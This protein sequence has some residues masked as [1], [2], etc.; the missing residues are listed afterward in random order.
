MLRAAR[1]AAVPSG[2]STWR[3]LLALPAAI[4]LSLGIAACGDDDGEAGKLKTTQQNAGVEITIGSKDDTEQV[5]LGQ[6]YAQA[7]EAAGYRVR[8][9]AD[10]RTSEAA[11]GAVESGQISGYPEYLS[12][13]LESFL[14]VAPA[15][16]PHDPVQAAARAK[17]GLRAR[18][19][20]AFKP[21]PYNRTYDVG[22]LVSR[23][24]ELTVE[25]LTD[26]RGK[27]Q[28]LTLAAPA[29]CLERADC[30]GALEQGYGL[31]FSDT[32]S[33]QVEQ[34]YA[35]LDSGQADLSILSTPDAKLFVSPSVYTSL[36]DDEGLFPAGNPIF[37][38]SRR[39]V[40]EAG[41]D[42]EATIER[43]Q[44]ALDLNAIQELNALVNI[45]GE[46]PATVARDYLLEE[47]YLK[48]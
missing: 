26:L 21:A 23:A 10:L 42:F 9:E 6:I 43:V 8:L 7:L 48:G 17:A 13:A 20:V 15:D 45:D 22:L 29:E 5:I 36:D 18:G 35:V 34:R 46:D 12:T 32:R 38:A 4:A 39:A 33:S 11:L 31:Q 28:N 30:L 41:P 44:G 37:I 47:G 27:S 25:K 1:I 19:L 16:L 3:A 2:D 24:D 40:N 14:G